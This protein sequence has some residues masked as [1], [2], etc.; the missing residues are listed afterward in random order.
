MAEVANDKLKATY[1]RKKLGEQEVKYKPWVRDE[2]RMVINIMKEINRKRRN[3]R[4]AEQE[5]FLMDC[6]RDE[7]KKVQELVKE[8]VTKSDM[9]KTE[10]IRNCAN[11]SK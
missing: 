9:K 4:V 3:T 7:K 5:K 8:V 11:K 6:Y 10:D 1:S 2:I